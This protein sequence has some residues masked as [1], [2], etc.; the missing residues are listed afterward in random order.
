L[1]FITRTCTDLVE[2]FV[3]RGREEEEEGEEEERRKRAEGN[4]YWM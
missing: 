1:N 4:E 2:E 3:Y